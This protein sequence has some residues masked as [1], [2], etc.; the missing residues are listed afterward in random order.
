MY[1]NHSVR[2][3]H[4]D[5][6]YMHSYMYT[7]ELADLDLQLQHNTCTT[8]ALVVGDGHRLDER[9]TCSRTSRPLGRHTVA[10]TAATGADRRRVD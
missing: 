3:N 5:I 8:R 10:V 4:Y 9:L 7:T 1:S 2:Y 6:V